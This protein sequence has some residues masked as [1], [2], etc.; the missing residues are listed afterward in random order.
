M[1]AYLLR[2]LLLM[3][4]TLIGVTVVVFGVMAMAPGGIGGAEQMDGGGMKSRE[5][6]R[7]VERI[8]RHYALD[9][10][11][12]VQ[13]ARWVNHV[14]PVGFEM[15]DRLVWDESMWAQARALLAAQP[16]AE[17]P[18]AV[19]QALRAARVMAGYAGQT[20]LEA[21][22]SVVATLDD[23]AGPQAFGLFAVMDIK[24]LEPEE[25]QQRIRQAQAHYGLG[26][27]QA[28]FIGFLAAEIEGQARVVFSRPTFKKPDLG[29]SLRGGKVIDK[30]TETLPI[31]LLLNLLTLPIIYI[32]AIT[33]GVWAARHR[34]GAFDVGSNMSFMALWSLPVMVAGMLA[35][36]FL[37][38]AQ[39]PALRWF[40]ANGLHDVNAGQMPFFPRWDGAGFERGWLLDFAWHCILP[41]VCM[42]YG[43]FAFMSRVQRGAVLEA[44]GADYVRTARAKGLSE[45]VVLWRHAFSNSLLTLVT[46]ISG[47]IPSLF[48]GSFVVEMI[49]GINGM[50]RLM[51]EAASTKD[52]EVVMAT[53]LVG[54]LIALLC[55]IAR[56]LAYA[57]VDPR[58]SY[59]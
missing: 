34:G 25:I 53:T 30:I 6:K 12:W 9:R 2:R 8:K 59:E 18:A 16:L 37:A 57:V 31:T 5:A 49:F 10:P 24:P 58:V 47:I 55:D 20:P 46:M 11:F 45:G 22:R 26:V 21:A 32:V 23:P 51:V 43:G 27:A 13:Y 39:Y 4:P 1:L 56:D 7:Q 40:P 33:S 15:S 19:E 41:V 50:G 36:T 42:A 28:Q 14:S 54:G 17:D 52:F 44:L 38:S 48:V 29:N 3:I 35:I